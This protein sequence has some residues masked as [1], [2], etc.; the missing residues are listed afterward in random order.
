M[1]TNFSRWQTGSG[2]QSNMNMNEVLAN[3]AS[4]LL[5]GVRGEGRL[6]HPNDDVNRGQSSNDVY[7]TAMHVAA[8]LEIR[9]S[10]L[11]ALDRLRTTLD[12][13]ARAFRDLL[14]IGRTHLQ[15]AT[16]LSLGQEFSGYVAQLDYCREHLESTLPGLRSL[17]I[18]GT[19]VGTG[20]N[21]PKVSA[22]QS[23]QVSPTNSVCPSRVPQTNLRH[24][25]VTR[26]S[27]R[28]MAR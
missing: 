28:P 16:P 21:A 13:K 7:P 5:G 15:D 25:P 22:R 23:R 26:R 9:D 4:E 17:A 14:K 1:A 6:V 3:R 19:A 24:W 20:L 11:P 8:A 27:W 10:M 18:G 12:R 2:T